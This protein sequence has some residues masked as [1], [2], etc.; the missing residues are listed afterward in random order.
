MAKTCPTHSGRVVPA[1]P[2]LDSTAPGTPALSVSGRTVQMIPAAGEL[3]RWWVVRSRGATAW[4]TRVVFGDARLF[5]LDQDADRVVL[6]AVDQAGNASA[7]M[8]WTRP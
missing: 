2:W 4:T 8:T 5:T 1:S 6:T 3:P 7:G